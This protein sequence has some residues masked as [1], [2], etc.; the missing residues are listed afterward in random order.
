MTVVVQQNLQC[1]SIYIYR[2]ACVCVRACVF[3]QAYT[4]RRLWS[5][6]NKIW[7]THADS[8]RKGSGQNKNLPVWPRGHM[9]GGGVLGDQKLK[10]GEI[11]QTTGPIG[12]IFGT[13]IY[14]DSSGNEHGLENNYPPED[15]RRHFEGFIWSKTQ[16]WPNGWPDCRMLCLS[17]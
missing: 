2:S 12:T 16:M 17:Q 14:A 3:F 7:H 1:I 13:H 4:R 8:P 5:D 9:G 11:C 6:R 15:P 10:N